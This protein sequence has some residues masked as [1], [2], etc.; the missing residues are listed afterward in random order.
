MKMPKERI[1]YDNYN[2]WETYTDEVLKEMA[3]DCGWVDSE[4]EITDAKLE[5]WRYE[6]METD[7]E[8]EKEMLVDYFKDKIVGFFGEIGRWDGTYKAGNIGEFMDLFY[9]AMTDCDYFKFYDI[10]GHLYLTCSHHDGTNCFEIKEV[11]RKGY[12]YLNRWEY[13]WDD[14]RT[15][16][17]IHNQIFNRYSK[18]PRFAQKVFG[19]KA[20]ETEEVTKGGLIDRLNNE[21]RSN[22]C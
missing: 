12:Q 13:S 10:N 5:Q 8:N 9:K 4:D 22:Y 21:A 7:W 19:C 17:Y 20:R 1:I 3:M 14:K 2:P 16:E 18:L 15:E 6:E 11:T